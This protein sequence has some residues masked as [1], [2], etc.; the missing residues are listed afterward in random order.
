[1]EVSWKQKVAQFN[2]LEDDIAMASS[3]LTGPVIK[4]I[5]SDLEMTQQEF[6]EQ[7]C[8]FAI[9]RSAITGYER[10]SSYP[11]PATRILMIMGLRDRL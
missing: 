4:Q 1:M 7:I 5:R 9:N 6:T 8:G 10:E 11:H 2:F 3:W